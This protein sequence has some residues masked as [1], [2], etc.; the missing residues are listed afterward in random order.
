MRMNSD[1]LLRRAIIIIIAPLIPAL[2]VM[3]FLYMLVLSRGDTS[4]SI[5]F[6]KSE[7]A[8]IC[9]NWRA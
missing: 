7:W 6:V 8:A 1:L 5:A 2:M 4:K 9:A 3:H